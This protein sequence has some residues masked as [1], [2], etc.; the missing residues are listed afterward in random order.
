MADSEH[1]LEAIVADDKQT[2]DACVAEVEEPPQSVE[3]EII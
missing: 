1:C 3:L 2:V